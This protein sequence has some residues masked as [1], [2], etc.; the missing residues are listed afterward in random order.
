MLPKLDGKVLIIKDFTAVL[1]MHR[2]ARQEVVSTLRDA[3]DGEAARAFGTGELKSYRSRFGL[4]AAVTP[5]IDDYGSVNA[6]LGERFLRYR[7]RLGDNLEK[8]VKALANTA[9]EDAMRDE[10]AEAAQGVLLQTPGKPDLPEMIG[11]RISHLANFLA[12]GRSV[13]SRDRSGTVT[14]LPQPEVGTRVAKQLKKLALGVAMARNEQ[15]VSEDVYRIVVRVARDSL[16]SMRERVLERLWGLRGNF[17]ATQCIADTCELDTDTCRVWLSDLRLLGI[18][19]REGERPYRWQMK[20][21]FQEDI[22]A[23]QV[24]TTDDSDICP[25]PDTAPLIDNDPE[26]YEGCGVGGRALPHKPAVA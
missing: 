1:Q 14:Y 23:A 13:V 11:T 18:A 10:L 15:V 6:M 3:Y 16:P 9:K 21:E 2:E 20:P 19:D 22:D 4:L 5:V 17:E 12:T 8:I 7:L 24:W 26:A 25:P